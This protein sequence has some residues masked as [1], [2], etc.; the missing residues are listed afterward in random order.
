MALNNGVFRVKAAQVHSLVTYGLN[1]ASTFP[2][3]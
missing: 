2:L 3:L 1:R